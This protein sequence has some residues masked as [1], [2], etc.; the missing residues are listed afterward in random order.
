[1]IYYFSQIVTRLFDVIVAPFGDHRTVALSVISLLTGVALIFIFKATSNQRRIKETRDRF[2]ARILEMRL[3]QDDIV[4]IH[5]ALFA[6]L[7]TNL[8]YLRASIK[9]ILVLV[10]FVFVIFIQLDERYGRRALE[11]GE[12][13][14]LSVTLKDGLDP[15]SVPLSLAMGEGLATDSRPVRSSAERQVFWRIRAD[16]LGTHD[17]D[18]EVYDKNYRV[19]V[20]A[21][22]SNATVGHVRAARSWSNALLFPSLP[23]IPADSPIK[24][25]EL[26][27]P[28]ATYPL[29]VWKT[30]WMVVFIV[31]SFIGAL[32]PK[33]LFGIQ[34]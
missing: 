3:Y 1:M 12:K 15:M 22:R 23:R 4:L 10:A 20:R 29:L 25:V 6:A 33:F 18:I 2:K 8:A 13:V 19:P 24:K 31:F 26:R 32:I 14:L 11:P 9:P 34:I 27:Y 16:Q 30:H 28:R 5:K 17:I 7:A 21:E